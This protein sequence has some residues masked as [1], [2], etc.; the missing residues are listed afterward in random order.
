MSST[1]YSG[2]VQNDERE[3][4]DLD[5]DGHEGKESDDQQGRHPPRDEGD[6]AHVHA[7]GFGTGT[8]SSARRTTVSADTPSNSASEPT[9]TVPAAPAPP[10]PPARTASPGRG[11]SP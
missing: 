11:W 2:A 9:G 10:L 4:G 6:D 7:S 8:E 3:R 1:E 5:R